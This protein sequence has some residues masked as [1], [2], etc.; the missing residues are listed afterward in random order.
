[1]FDTIASVQWFTHIKS[2][3]MHLHESYK[4]ANDHDSLQ[5]FFL[6]SR[7][8]LPIRMQGNQYCNLKYS[9]AKFSALGGDG[10]ST[11]ENC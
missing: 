9:S 10:V 5:V 1:M 11:N 8:S 6:W 7:T 2:F 4:W 3:E